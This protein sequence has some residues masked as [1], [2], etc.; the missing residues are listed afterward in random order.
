MTQRKVICLTKEE[1]ARAAIWNY[2]NP[3]PIWTPSG[4]SSCSLSKISINGIIFPCL[5]PKQYKMFVKIAE[6]CI[7]ALDKNRGK[8]YNLLSE[9]L[10]KRDYET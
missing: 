7:F 8:V 4:K 9:N 2:P 10:R 3:R 1:I 5:L 6:R